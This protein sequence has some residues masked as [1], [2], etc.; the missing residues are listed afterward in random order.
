MFKQKNP[1]ELNQWHKKAETIERS[2]NIRKM[3]ELTKIYFDIC[4]IYTYVT[5]NLLV[6]KQLLTYYRSRII[7]HKVGT[8]TCIFP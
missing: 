6:V 7:S 8:K 1:L 2:A 3:N 5:E 4:D